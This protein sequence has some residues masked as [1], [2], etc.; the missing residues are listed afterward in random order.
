MTPRKAERYDTSEAALDVLMHE[1]DAGVL[2]EHDDDVWYRYH[3]GYAQAALSVRLPV[4]P[5][6]TYGHRE[7]LVF[8]DNLL[9]E[10]DTRDELAR[11][12]Q[13]DRSDVAGLLGRVGGECAGAVS[14]WTPGAERPTTATYRALS[15]QELSALFDERH[16]ERLTAA[17]LESRQVM[18]GVQRKLVLRRWNNTWQLPLDGAAG[19]HI[20]K[21]AS[22]RYDGLVANELACLAFYR[23]LG[24]AVPAAHAIASEDDSTEPTL[25]AIERYDRVEA[26]ATED[27]STE[28]TSTDARSLPPI[29]RVHQEDMCQVTGRLPRR[30]Y[31]RDGGP[32]V[33]DLAAAIRRYSVRPAIDLQDLLTAVVANVCLGNGDAHGKNFALLHSTS[34][35]RLAPFYDV[36]STE[37]YQSLSPDLSMRFGHSYQPHTLTTDDVQR[38][39][40]DLGVA[41]AKVRSTIEQVTTTLQQAMPD[42][43]HATTAMV[44]GEVVALSRLEALMRVRVPSVAALARRV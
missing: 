14:V 37:V 26:T 9:L 27:T 8:F 39:A 34:G 16:G 3:D 13:D 19:T 42:V 2:G 44:G 38:L 35:A 29:T 23:A 4:R 20:I 1:H 41:P 12:R 28:A 7:T 24:L 33:R 6:M 11:V 32:G 17:M 22:G 31:Q 5:L 30:K 25:L 10:S 21:R 18:S 43:L 36:V 40:A 15:G